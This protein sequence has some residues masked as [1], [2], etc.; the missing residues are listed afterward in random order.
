[1]I[2]GVQRPRRQALGR[3]QKLCEEEDPPR[4]TELSSSRHRRGGRTFQEGEMRTLV[5]VRNATDEWKGLEDSKQGE[6]VLM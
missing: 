2:M 3:R 4:T 6:G 1:M 5:R